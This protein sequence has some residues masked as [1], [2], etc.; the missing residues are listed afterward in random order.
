MT[1]GRTE[2]GEDTDGIKE[3]EYYTERKTRNGK[4]GRGR[5]KEREERSTYVNRGKVYIQYT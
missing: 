2:G 1:Q 4:E 3:K 5:G